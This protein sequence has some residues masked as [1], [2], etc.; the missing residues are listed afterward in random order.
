MYIEGTVTG[1]KYSIVESLVPTICCCPVGV[2][3][4]VAEC[5]TEIFEKQVKCLYDA[6][7]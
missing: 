6:G 7:L 4:G 1:G 5:R 2:F 3:L